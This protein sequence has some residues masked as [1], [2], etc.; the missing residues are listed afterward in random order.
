MGLYFL[1]FS[2]QL[3]RKDMD[4]VLNEIKNYIPEFEQRPSILSQNVSIGPGYAQ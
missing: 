2:E 1:R 4:I 3:I